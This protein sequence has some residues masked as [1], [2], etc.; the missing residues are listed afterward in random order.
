LESFFQLVTLGSGIPS[1]RQVKLLT[2][3]TCSSVT[4]NEQ[5]GGSKEK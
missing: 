5:V 1:P 2:P 4:V 3:P